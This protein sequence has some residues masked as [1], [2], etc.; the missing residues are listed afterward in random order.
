MGEKK[1]DNKLTRWGG[2]ASVEQQ[3]LD[4][5]VRVTHAHDEDLFCIIQLQVIV[6]QIANELFDFSFQSVIV[7]AG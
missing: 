1:R 7:R 3:H 5:N 2:F 4:A 6:P